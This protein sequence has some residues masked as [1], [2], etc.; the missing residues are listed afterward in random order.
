[1]CDAHMDEADDTTADATAAAEGQ[2][3]S[4]MSA[5]LRRRH[6]KTKLK[7]KAKSLNKRPMGHN[8]HLS[9]LLQVNQVIYSSFPISLSSFKAMA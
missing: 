6:K 2:H 4:Y 8:P 7:K 9:Q 5:M 3:D 1:M